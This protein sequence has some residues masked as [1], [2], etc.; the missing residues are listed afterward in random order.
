MWSD[1]RSSTVKGASG[2]TTR[3]PPTEPPGGA[4]GW[5]DRD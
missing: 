5:T 3:E 2:V 1:V 4:T